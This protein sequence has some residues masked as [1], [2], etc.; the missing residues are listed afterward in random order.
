MSKSTKQ[1]VII[2][3]DDQNIGRTRDV[4]E[5]LRK[6]GLEVKDIMEATGTITG[7]ASA[8][9]MSALSAVAGVAAVEQARSY[10]LPSPGADVQ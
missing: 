5:Q 10:Q 3:V 4:A 9:K 7:T 1:D 6:A 2:S 8:A